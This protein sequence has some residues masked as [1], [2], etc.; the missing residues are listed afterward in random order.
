MRRALLLATLLAAPT[1]ASAQAAGQVLFQNNRI[2]P[3][4]INA[5][6]CDPSSTAQVTLNWNPQFINNNTSVPSNGSYL[7]CASNTAPG[8]N[9]TQCQCTNSGTNV[10]PV[11]FAAQVGSNA[12]GATSATVSTSGMVTA[13]NFTCGNNGSVVFVCVQGI[14]NGSNN[15]QTNF[16]VASASVTIS[17]SLPQVPVITGITPGDGA[18]N[19]SWEPG[20]VGTGSAITQQVEI[21]VEPIAS[22]TGAFDTGGLRSVG[23]FGASPARVERLMNTVIYD[24]RA[25]AFSDTGNVSDFTPAGV[26]TGMPMFVNDF[27]NLYKKDGGRE[28]GGCG[29]GAAGPVGLGILLATLALIRRRK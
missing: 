3:N 11:V 2:V 10:S 14:V 29:A 5:A 28:T 27:W 25:R 17:T 1:L 19:V 18:L 12:F 9:G 22:T 24:V 8:T 15:P 20:S 16:A 23:T 4:S 26:T 7:I 21:E 13:S 6:E